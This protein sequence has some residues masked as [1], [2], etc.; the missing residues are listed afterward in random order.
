MLGHVLE[1]QPGAGRSQVKRRYAWI[2]DR[3][4]DRD[5]RYSATKPVALPAHVDLRALMSP[6]EDQGDLGSCTA[7]A[8]AGAMEY[9]ENVARSKSGPHIV[10]STGVTMPDFTDISRLFIYYQ[11]R[12]LEGTVGQDAGAEIR[13]G[14]KVC[15]KIGACDERLW[16]YVISRFRS[17]PSRQA[18]ADAAKRKIREYR[19]IVGMSALRSCLAEG[20]PVVFGFTVYES[21]ESEEVARTGVVPMPKENERELGGHA[22]LAVGYDDPSRMLIVRNSWG[23]AWGDKGYFRMPYGYVES[24]QLSDDFW[25]IR[26]ENFA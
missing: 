13:D 15:A 17:A 4:D 8:I 23:E 19:R 10:S 16:P 22:V 12:K 6:V 3:Y 1:Q 9:L 18:I 5:L 20:F 21:F 25:T 24:H 7:N 26:T 2:R 11:E 14:V